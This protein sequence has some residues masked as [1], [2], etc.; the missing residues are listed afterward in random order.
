MLQSY[1]LD[2]SYEVHPSHKKAQLDHLESP[3]IV[4]SELFPGRVSGDSFRLSIHQN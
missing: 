4:T 3:Q 1:T 2:R